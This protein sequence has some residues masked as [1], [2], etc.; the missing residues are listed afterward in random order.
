M[1]CSRE[2]TGS[3]LRAVPSGMLPVREEYPPPPGRFP[4]AG[5]TGDETLVPAAAR[6]ESPRCSLRAGSV[7][8]GSRGTLDTET[9]APG[10]DSGKNTGTPAPPA[11]A[12]TA[13]AAAPAYASHSSAETLHQGRCLPSSRATPEP[14]PRET[15]NNVPTAAASPQAGAGSTA[16]S[17][18]TAG[19]VPYNTRSSCFYH[20]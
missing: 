16:T 12:P 8:S 1:L 11:P 6:H 19:F 13:A 3:L 15:P 4:P 7:C 2:G 10:L 9:H 14:S 5:A 17:S 20:R 18:K